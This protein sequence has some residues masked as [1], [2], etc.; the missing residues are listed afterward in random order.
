[1][2]GRSHDAGALPKLV[3]Q[4]EQFKAGH[5]LDVPDLPFMLLAALPLSCKDWV[6]IAK[7]ASWQ[8]TRMNLNTFARHGVFEED[9]VAGLIAAP[10]RAAGEIRRGARIPVPPA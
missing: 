6:E 7:N 4:F 10:L 2:L 3:M 1:M 9:D 8:T 5:V